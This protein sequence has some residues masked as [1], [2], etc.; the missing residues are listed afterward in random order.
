[1]ALTCQCVDVIAFVV[2]L[3]PYILMSKFQPYNHDISFLLMHLR[4]IAPRSTALAP[5]PPH[6]NHTLALALQSRQPRP[7]RACA[8]A[9]SF[10][11]AGFC[12][13]IT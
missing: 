8:P 13:L 5:A 12:A 7:H 6:I 1:M 2:R 10:V 4:S 11:K 3:V 9:Q